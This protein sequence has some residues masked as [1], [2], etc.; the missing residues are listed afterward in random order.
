MEIE[1]EVSPLS[2]V[3]VFEKYSMLDQ[4]FS[5]IDREQVH[6]AVEPHENGLELRFLNDIGGAPNR[7]HLRIFFPA[8]NKCC[9]LFYKRSSIPYSR[10]RFSYGGIVVDARS[11]ARFDESDIREWV[12]F[13]LNGFQPKFR[14]KSL[15]KSI[16]YTVPED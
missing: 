7:G 9:L 5:I 4:L 12:L 11:G 15:K 2:H 13:L 8:E 3:P 16:P 6:V 1:T 14:P 10:D